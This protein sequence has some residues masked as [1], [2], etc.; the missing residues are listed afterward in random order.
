M[1][2]YVFNVCIR[3]QCIYTYSMNFFVVL[4]GCKRVDRSIF[5]YEARYITIKLQKIAFSS[6]IIHK[7]VLYQICQHF[8]SLT[9]NSSINDL[10]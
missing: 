6:Y 1:Y 2:L 5:L 3:I 10:K 4:Y 8:V 7:L 9:N